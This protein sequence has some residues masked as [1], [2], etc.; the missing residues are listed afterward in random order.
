MK[1]SR[2]WG[3]ESDTLTTDRMGKGKSIGVKSKTI[4]GIALCA[5]LFVSGY[6]VSGRRELYPDLVLSP[7]E[8]V[9]FQ[10]GVVFIELGN[11]VSGDGEF[12]IIA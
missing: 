4:Y 8:Y 6:R 12:G 5:V 3:S 7:G 9:Y 11:L 1:S 2:K 10:Q